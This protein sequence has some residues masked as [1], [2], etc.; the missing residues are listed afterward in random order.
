MAEVR[1]TDQ[2]GAESLAPFSLRKGDVIVADRGYGKRREHCCSLQ[3]GGTGASA[4]CSQHLPNGA[5]RRN[6]PGCGG[7]ADVEQGE[8]THVQ[9]ALCCFE[10]QTYPVRVLAQSLPP[11]AAERALTA[12]AVSPADDTADRSRED[13]LFQVGMGAARQHAGPQGLDSPTRL[14]ALPGR[15]GRWSSFLNG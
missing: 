11:E 10:K 7:L 14:A 2:H 4:F 6:A 9:E 12:N 15:D 5:G 1:L 8:G 3:A 13:T